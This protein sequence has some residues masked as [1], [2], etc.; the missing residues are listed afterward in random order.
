MNIEGM[1]RKHAKKNKIFIVSKY[2]EISFE[3]IL[4]ALSSLQKAIDTLKNENE[5]KAVPKFYSVNGDGEI[6]HV[7]VLLYCLM[8]RIPFVP[9]NRTL[10]RNVFLRK[11]LGECLEIDCRGGQISILQLNLIFNVLNVPDNADEVLLKRPSSR[12]A[13][14]ESLACLFPTSGTTGEPKLIA[15]SNSQLYRGVVYVSAALELREDDRIAGLL[16]LDF[17]Y[18]LNQLLIALYLGATYISC[19]ISNPKNSF[20]DVLRKQRVTVVPLM[21]FLIERY[22]ARVKLEIDTP[23]LVTS[24]GGAITDK[25]RE[26][27]KK[28]FKNAQLIPMYGLSEGFRATISNSLL[29]S[30]SPESVGKPIGDTV[31]TIRDEEGK[32]VEKGD[33]GEIWQSGGCLSWGYWKDPIATSERF[34]PDPDYPNRLWLRSGDLGYFNEH[35]SLVIVGRKSFQIKKY[36]IRISIDEIEKAMN[37]LFPT[38]TMLA[39]PI[40]KS[41]TES[42]FDLVYEADENLNDEIMRKVKQFL[43]VELWPDK[44]RQINKIPMNVY[45]GKPDRHRLRQMLE[46]GE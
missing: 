7:T 9:N 19:N 35:G 18:G 33:V 26:I 21:P 5:L 46:S 12:G 6:G 17:D 32:E 3:H 42:D 34:V 8:H 44:A 38:L 16:S 31:V 45:G 41:T 30:H 37:S 43:P 1:L 24:S 36:G 22:F 13:G 11:K 28:V 10:A 23:R 39:I 29:D 14:G 40:E 27:I 25:H 20:Q 4:S 2:M 15:V